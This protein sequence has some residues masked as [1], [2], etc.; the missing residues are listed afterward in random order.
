[1]RTIGLIGGMSW[2]ST[3]EYYRIINQRVRERLGGLHSAQCI[4]YSVDFEKVERLQRKGEWR[5]LA[6]LMASIARKLEDAG[7]QGIVICSNTMHKAAEDVQK[8]LNIPLIHMVDATAV[9]IERRGLRKIA[10]LGT[11]FTME[12]EFYR[13]RLKEK[14]GIET[15]IPGEKDRAETHRII[16][17]ELCRGILKQSSRRQLAGIVKKLAARGA[18]GVILGCTELPL[19]LKQEDAAIPLFNTT[20]IHA[21]AAVDYMLSQPTRGAARRFKHAR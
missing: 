21:K 3:Q 6:K 17:R 4:L 5:R 2:E 16:Y 12:D 20:E 9:E 15:I 1:M 14:H 13:R 10:L 18:Q 8:S 11:R 7:A 19:L